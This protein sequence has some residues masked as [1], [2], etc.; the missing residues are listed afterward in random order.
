MAGWSWRSETLSESSI[1]EEIRRG[2]PESRRRSRTP[3]ILERQAPWR[4]VR[5]PFHPFEII[6][7]DEL[8]SIHLASLSILENIGIS[9]QS[10]RARALLARHGAKVTAGEQVVR[11]DRDFVLEAIADAP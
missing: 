11:F 9:V 6:S 7:A 4:L 1:G 5:N 2:R 3:G 10:E 8:E